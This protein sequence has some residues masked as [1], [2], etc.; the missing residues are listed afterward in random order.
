MSQTDD[1][2]PDDTAL[3]GEYALHLMDAESRRAFERRLK[4]EPVLRALLRTWEEGLMPLADEFEQV[5]PP[6]HLKAAIDIR[7]FGEPA[8]G[9]ARIW[10][11]I[12]RYKASIFAVAAMLFVAA[13]LGP[14]F[15]QDGGAPTYSAEISA[16]DRALVLTA[17]FDPATGALDIT[18]VAGTAPDGRVLELWLIADGVPAAISL[19]V[20]PNDPQTVLAVPAE[21]VAV[22]NGGT[23][24]IT[25]EPPGG[26]PLG[27]ATGSV[28]A[29]GTIAAS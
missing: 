5:A 11:W 26:A 2:K 21:L 27:V 23:L 8:T 7:L 14:A 9:A 1:H 4:A 15:L 3:A 29:I 6:A 16:E 24:A 18:R 10:G 28:L 22:M 19:G 13:Y 20:L 17:Q 12:G 25:D